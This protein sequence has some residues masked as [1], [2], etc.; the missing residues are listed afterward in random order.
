MQK[1]YINDKQNS[2]FYDNGDVVITKEVEKNIHLSLETCGVSK[3][4][5]KGDT[6]VSGKD[7]SK[8]F[9]SDSELSIAENSTDWEMINNN[10]FDIT[11]TKNGVVTY[12]DSIVSIKEFEDILKDSKKVNELINY[13]ND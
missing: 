12:L 6:L 5:Y 10:W 4:K 2:F 13:A 3:V 9:N 7:F 11:V 8:R 1:Y